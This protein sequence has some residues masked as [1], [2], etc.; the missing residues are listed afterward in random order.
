MSCCRVTFIA[1]SCD[2][3]W[4][5]PSRPPASPPPATYPLPRHSG[6]SVSLGHCGTDGKG[7]VGVPAHPGPEGLRRQYSLHAGRG[8]L[9]RLE[10]VGLAAHRADHLL[11]KLLAELADTL[12]HCLLLLQVL[13][14]ELG[15]VLLAHQ[16]ALLD[17]PLVRGDLIMLGLGCR[18][19]IEHG[20]DLRRG[21]LLLHEGVVF[22][23]ETLNG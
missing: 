11:A 15:A 3:R 10:L 14:Q 20:G 12:R 2:R 13:P 23:L 8:L 19:Q 17:Q 4:P 6:Q 7:R 22:L 5:P 1:A 9:A 18:A 21:V 16:L